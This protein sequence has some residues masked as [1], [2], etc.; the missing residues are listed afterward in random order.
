MLE[1]LNIGACRYVGIRNATFVTWVVDVDAVAAAV[2]VDCIFC[3]F[4]I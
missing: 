1:N 3:G 2:V 4:V